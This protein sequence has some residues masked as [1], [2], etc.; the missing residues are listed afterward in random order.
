MQNIKIALWRIASGLGFIGLNYFIAQQFTRTDFFSE[1]CG[2]GAA[3]TRQATTFWPLLF[4]MLL[5]WGLL[6]FSL[7]GFKDAWAELKTR[8]V[9]AV[10]WWG[11][12][13]AWL[14]MCAYVFMH[15][16]SM[17]VVTHSF[18]RAGIFLA[19]VASGVGT[20][21][22]LIYL[23]SYS[24]RQR[25]KALLADLANI[26]EVHQQEIIQLIDQHARQQAFQLFYRPTL[27]LNAAAVAHEGGNPLARRDEI[28]PLNRD[29][30]PA[31]FLLQLPLHAPRLGAAWQGR[32]LCVY[33]RDWGILLRSYAAN[34]LSELVS[35][36]N[37]AADEHLDFHALQAIA[38]PLVE[39][40]SEEDDDEGLDAKQLLAQ[41]PVL[42]AKLAALSSQPVALLSIILS[43][44][45][46]A[47]TSENWSTLEADILVGGVPHFIQNA[48]DPVCE[49][50]REPMR[51]L[52]QF[53]DMTNDLLLGDA[54]VGYVYGCDAHPE[55]CQG[56]IDCC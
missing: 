13:S 3:A 20:I 32:V 46:Y 15:N 24:S 7:L 45:T 35:M 53:E 8:S 41:R 2:C 36:S 17:V 30:T 18:T 50:C 6:A 25:R 28:W 4:L 47:R 26:D 21:A 44:A 5:G 34:E 55:H 11:L 48:H 43:T 56:F 1:V 19:V 23:W 16:L 10:L 52:L 27:G 22:L 42:Q 39:P 33:L 31:I 51:F 12:A 49:I 37:P 29:G 9:T 54:G 14:L 38:I 40:A